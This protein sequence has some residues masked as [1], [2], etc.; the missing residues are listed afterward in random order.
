[1]SNSP[2]PLLGRSQ[3]LTRRHGRHNR[4][5]IRQPLQAQHLLH[6]VRILGQI[7]TPRRRNHIQH[8]V[9]LRNLAPH[10]AQP[11]DH[12][13][14]SI[15]HPGNLARTRHRHPNRG[16][17]RH[18]PHHGA[19]RGNGATRNILQQGAGHI[20]GDLHQCWIHAPL[21]PPRRLRT[22]LMTPRRPGRHNRI[23]RS[24]LKIH[25][26]GISRNLRRHAPHHSRQRLD[27]GI[28]ANH[29]IFRI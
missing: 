24:S 16:H 23:P 17:H 20:Q 5:N 12:R 13:L 21:K 6:Q 3:P 19:A 26:R 2:P 22:Q 8:A 4:G 11:T 7:R 27:A 1:M 28:V 10:L 29:H 9:M 14:R 25:I 15:I 18:L